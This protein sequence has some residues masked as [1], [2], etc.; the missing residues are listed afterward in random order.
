MTIHHMLAVITKHKASKASK[1]WQAP[2]DSKVSI[3]RAC[4]AQ[5]YTVQFCTVYKFY[6]IF[7]V[8]LYE[9]LY[10]S[11]ALMYHCIMLL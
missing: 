11:N 9:K 1:A 10:K 8:I 6:L 5:N 4:I 3:S 2:K 7:Y